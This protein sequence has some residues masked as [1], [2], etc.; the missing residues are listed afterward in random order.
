MGIWCGCGSK[1]QSWYHEETVVIAE[2]SQ[3]L[4]ELYTWKGTEGKSQPEMGTV[5]AQSSMVTWRSVCSDC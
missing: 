5:T 4:G 1:G 2:A 3:S